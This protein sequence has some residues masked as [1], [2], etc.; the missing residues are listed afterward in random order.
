MNDGLTEEQEDKLLN[1]LKYDSA[2]SEDEIKYAKQFKAGVFEPDYPTLLTI[3]ETL[4]LESKLLRKS[5]EECLKFHRTLESEIEGLETTLRTVA[6]KNGSSGD[7]DYEKE[8]GELKQ[9]RESQ[10]NM[11]ISLNNQLDDLKEQLKLSHSTIATK[12]EQIEGLISINSNLVSSLK[13][14]ND[15]SQISLEL[16]KTYCNA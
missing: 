6:N 2:A 5:V 3:A 13:E 11:L 4:S 12:N 8:I 9:I 15:L 16:D 1:P 10:K 14:Y 7:L